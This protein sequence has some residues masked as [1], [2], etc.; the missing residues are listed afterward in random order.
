K[1]AEKKA[2]EAGKAEEVTGEKV[3]KKAE[4][5]AKEAEKAR[6]K[7]EKERKKAEEKA[8]KEAEKKAKEAGKAEE[9]TAEKLDKEAVKKAKAEE[10]ARKEAEK[11]RKK[12]EEKAKKEADKASKEAEK[13]RKEADKANKEAEKKEKE[14]EE[15]RIKADKASVKDKKK[16]QKEAEKKAKAAAEARKKA[17]TANIEADK[18]AVAAAE[19]KKKA[20]MIGVAVEEKPAEVEEKPAEVPEEK[21]EE[22]LDEKARKEAE[23]RAKEEKK[24]Q[25]KAEKERK[26]AERKARRE[27]AKEARKKMP[28]KVRPNAAAVGGKTGLI[29]TISADILNQDIFRLN[30]HLEYF[31]AKRRLS[32]VAPGDYPVYQDVEIF[33]TDKSQRL[34]GTAAISYGAYEWKKYPL[35]LEVTF[36]GTGYSHSL[37]SEEGG[38]SLVQS[39]GDLGMGAKL[40]YGL[41]KGIGLGF[42][43]SLQILTKSGD[44]G[45]EGSATSAEFKFLSTFELAEIEDLPFENF[46][47]TIHLNLG[48]HLDNSDEIKMPGE[49][50]PEA[51]Y[52][53]GIIRGSQFLLNFGFEYPL[54]TIGRIGRLLKKNYLD[55]YLEYSVEDILGTD[56]G[57]SYSESNQRITLGPRLF[58]LER[59]RLAVDLMFDIGLSKMVS[60]QIGDDVCSEPGWRL[61]SGLSYTFLPAPRVAA[62]TTGRIDGRVTD[63][64]TGKPIERAIISFPGTELSSIVTDADG[65][66][67][68]CELEA[69]AVEVVASRDG[70]LS[71]TKKVMVEANRTITQDFKLEK[72][73]EVG[74]L[75]GKVTDNKIK[76]LAAVITFD[77]PIAS[78]A[79]D[80]KTGEYTVKL[81][82][83]EYKVTATAEK[84]KPETKPATIK[85]KETTRLNFVLELKVVAP[86]KKPLAVLKAKK[87]EILEKI[88]FET[89]K[90]VL[91]SASHPILD[92]VAQILVDHPRVKILIEGHT[93][94]VGS[95][96]YNLNLSQSRAESVMK[97]LLDKGVPGARL[98]AAGFGESTPIADNTT[99]SGRARNRRVEFTIIS[100]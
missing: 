28:K 98:K 43:T 24:A 26:K 30:A 87:I 75:T 27:A 70:Y 40:A 76:P 52:A 11:A 77:K 100:Q 73:V 58:L 8:R 48:Y 80:P 29:R 78:V 38:T 16:A 35:G 88:H 32:Y 13:A 63:A 49:R 93:D 97:Y 10:K 61:I 37:V 79:T 55:F 95:E 36:A 44:L 39:L 89:G 46:P 6:K 5:E 9:V 47:L 21:V 66:Y 71:Q 19:A 23:K 33:P 64:K 51:E 53:L 85:D 67:I 74:V 12:A 25:E 81:P 62:P 92:D 90:A 54:D 17:D 42:D 31:Y 84:Y 1:E 59:Q 41:D 94:S 56:F 68:T 22:E 69:G 20:E 99:A 65:R 82:P 34:D 3:D 96:T 57:R 91:L 18:K 45:Y 72:L 2:K 60:A 15:A 83:G 50:L 86:P 14:A 4:K 7:A